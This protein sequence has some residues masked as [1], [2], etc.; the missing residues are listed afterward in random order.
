MALPVTSEALDDV[1]VLDLSEGVAG[2]FC[3]KLLAALGADVI[4]VEAPGRGDRARSYPPFAGDEPHPELSGLFLYLNTGKRSVTLDLAQASGRA[5]AGRLAGWADIV[6]EDFAPGQLDAWGL[7]HEALAAARPG[8]IVVSVTD[9]GQSGPYRDW[10]ATDLTALAL[11]GSLYIAGD[12]DREPL[13][14]GGR[15][16]QFFAGLSAFSGALL[17]LHYRDATGEGQHVDVSMLEGIAT[18]QEY[19]GAAWAYKREIRVRGPGHA[20]M[21]EVGDGYIGLMF[22]QAR[23]AA[24][25]ELIGR[26]EIEHDPRFEGTRQRR[27]N[28]AELSE[29]IAEW[30]EGKRKAD[31][32]HA[33]QAVQGPAGYVC[34][35]PDLIES[36]QFVE[37]EFFSEVDHP[38]SGPLLYPG[39]PLRFGTERPPLRR[40]PLL[41]EHNAEVYGELLGCSAADL[42]RMRGAGVI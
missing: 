32:Y 13:K 42:A 15:P 41:G 12:E 3:T 39:L 38:A 31:L 10:R 22:P 20:P 19:P 37:R 4:S 2:P 16:A 34:T 14:I 36:P 6:I 25:C 40:A 30:T 7:G 5:I 29:I 11:G 33:V 17:A 26:P 8:A 18:A 35:A 1:R 9:Y 21:F 23:W 28:M 27:D 24:F